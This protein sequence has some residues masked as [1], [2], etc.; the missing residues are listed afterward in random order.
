MP[1][2]EELENLNN[3]TRILQARFGGKIWFEIDAAPDTLSCEIIKVCL[4]PLI[5]N[6]V[7][8][9]LVQKGGRGRISIRIRRREGLLEIVEEDDGAGMDGATLARVQ[10]LLRQEAGLQAGAARPP[11]DGPHG[12]V[13][14]QNI[15]QRIRLYYGPEYGI[16]LS[17]EPGKGTRVTITVPAIEV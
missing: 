9:G 11:A 17:S 14:L 8:H 5:E 7:S 6:S 16:L 3:Y 13:G 10:A 1:V 15:N 4:Q 2:R 12:G